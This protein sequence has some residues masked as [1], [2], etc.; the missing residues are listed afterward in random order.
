MILR[1][2]HN[3]Q[4][5]ILCW[6]I[7]KKQFKLII[8]FDGG[9]TI[10]ENDNNTLFVD[11]PIVNNIDYVNH[12]TIKIY[13]SQ[14]YTDDNNIAIQFKTN[15]DCANFIKSMNIYN[16][17]LII[18]ELDNSST[19]DNDNIEIPSINNEEVQECLLSLLFN[20]EFKLFVKDVEDLLD[21]IKTNIP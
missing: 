16:K 8:T 18:K 15:I 21:N 19:I 17:S 9:I 11:F 20:E 1:Q 12:K 10:R 4:K 6:K 5:N 14:V 3:K 2:D 7:H 13:N